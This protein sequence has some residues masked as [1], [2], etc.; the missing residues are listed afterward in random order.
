MMKK[1]GNDRELYSLAR[2]PQAEIEA[3]ESA[4]LWLEI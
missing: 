1:E 3:V 2:P 4:F